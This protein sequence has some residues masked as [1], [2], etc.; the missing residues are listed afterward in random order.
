MLVVVITTIGC[1]AYKNGYLILDPINT[2][3]NVK[4]VTETSLTYYRGKVKTTTEMKYD[5]NK[6][7]HLVRDVWSHVNEGD[8]INDRFENVYEF[9]F[10]RKKL[11]KF[12]SRSV[13]DY[14]DVQVATF[15]YP[16]KNVVEFTSRYVGDVDSKYM[17]SYFFEKGKLISSIRSYSNEKDD[18]ISFSSSSKYERN[19]NGWLLKEE[20]NS[21][22]KNEELNHI[23]EYQY[24]KLDATGNWIKMITKTNEEEVDSVVTTREIMYY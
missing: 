21:T 8:S 6:N 22:S 18:M 14:P 2:K 16:S 17:V 9:E 23:R 1:N 3:G 7:G 10:E 13:G 11:T 19:G 24:P 20:Y 4:S 5:Y 12:Y 15:N